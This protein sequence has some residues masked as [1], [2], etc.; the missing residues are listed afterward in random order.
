[1]EDVRAEEEMMEWNGWEGKV[2][3]KGT[4]GNEKKSMGMGLDG[5]ERK[6]GKTM[7]E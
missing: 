7:K 5:K 1:M 4:E 2:G 6:G 3:C